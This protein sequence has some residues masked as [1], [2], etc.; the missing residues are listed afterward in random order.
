MYSYNDR[1][2]AIM[3]YELCYMQERFIFVTNNLCTIKY[4][5]IKIVDDILN[6]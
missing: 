3:F 6:I 1:T 2:D 5:T 4:I